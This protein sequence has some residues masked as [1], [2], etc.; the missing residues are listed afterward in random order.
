MTDETTKRPGTPETTCPYCRG[1]FRA[2]ALHD[3]I[4]DADRLADRVSE[5]ETLLARSQRLAANVA[6]SHAA[7]VRLLLG[8]RDRLAADL[9]RVTDERDA[10]VAGT[11]A[12]EARGR[13]H[14]RDALA[15]VTAER[16]EA[17]SGAARML[18]LG[19][20][21][22]TEAEHWLDGPADTNGDALL[23]T[24]LHAWGTETAIFNLSDLSKRRLANA[25][26]PND[27]A[28]IAAETAAAAN[29]AL[30]AD[31][32]ALRAQ[33]ATE[34]ARADREK[35]RADDNAE[36]IVRLYGV[37][38]DTSVQCSSL[39][40]AVDTLEAALVEV[41]EAVEAHRAVPK[42]P[43]LNHTVRAWGELEGRRMAAHD[44]VTAAIASTPTD[45]AAAR[46]RRVRA[47]AIDTARGL[48]TDTR[49]RF[50]EHDFYPL[51]NFAAFS[52]TWKG[53]RFDTSEA[54]Y[55][56]EKFPGMEIRDD[57]RCAPSAHV[58][59][60]LAEQYR[61]ARRADWDDVKVD[62]MRQILRAKV[63]QHEYVRRKLLATGDREMV[64][65]SWRDDFWG[66]GPNRDG[67]N[68]LGKLW[69][70]LRNAL[71]SEST[72]IDREGGER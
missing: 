12:A 6:A 72:H 67:Q 32:D 48:D 56:W 49:V 7:E 60:K 19:W 28:D 59:F 16:D 17:R 11:V 20:E 63:D 71:R 66:W 31:R 3:A 44:R 25:T 9:A 47:E 23:R 40:L 55:H 8:D 51:S 5:A 2:V 21:M 65:D 50:Y 36:E 38:A 30:V 4:A 42:D 15:R 37:T 52:L 58:A 18:D 57:I 34:R 39:L 10:A 14:G 43:G 22:H 68:M 46:D 29:A 24:A 1:T 26:K 41:R 61:S 45:L 33:L 62:I 53:F 64:E 13:A 54:A 35:K 70:E 69:M 27:G